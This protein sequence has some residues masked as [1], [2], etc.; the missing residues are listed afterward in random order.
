MQK[1]VGRLDE[2]KILKEAFVSNEAEMIAVIGR[3]RVGKTFLIKETYKNEIVFS[4]TGVQ[5]ASLQEQL[6]N[7]SY[8]LN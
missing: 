3:R 6:S 2:I 5:N 8:Q 7:F 1:F 4:I